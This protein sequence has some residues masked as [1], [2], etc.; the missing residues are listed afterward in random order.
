MGQD[1]R[2][3][4][5]DPGRGGDPQREVCGGKRG[6]NPQEGAYPGRGSQCR[7]IADHRSHCP[8]SWHGEPHCCR[9][10]GV[11]WQGQPLLVQGIPLMPWQGGLL[12]PRGDSGAPEQRGSLQPQGANLPQGNPDPPEPRGSLQPP[13]G[14]AAARGATLAGEGAGWRQVLRKA[15]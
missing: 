3:Q 7:Q 8:C 15:G 13:A 12:Q 1:L 2:K 10:G 9:V 14:G 5:Q 11:P 6:E 4:L